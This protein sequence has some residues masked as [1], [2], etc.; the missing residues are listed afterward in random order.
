MR[1]TA[2]SAGRR[3]G[4]AALLAA[5]IVALV[6]LAG[7][8][9]GTDSEPAV[10]PDSQLPVA[11]QPTQDSTP[12]HPKPA[13]ACG[14]SDCVT[15]YF[16]DPT[17]GDLV[18][19]TR[20]LEHKSPLTPQAA[21]DLLDSGPSIAEQNYQGYTSYIGGDDTSVPQLTVSPPNA[22]GVVTVGLDP[23]TATLYGFTYYEALGQIVWTLD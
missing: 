20:I 19:V 22:G 23:G 6:A 13:P 18:P 7:C 14:A 12:L 9:I 15:L 16:V 11:L 17:T 1:A 2:T 21:L 10:V 5:A 4:R 3:W 8:G